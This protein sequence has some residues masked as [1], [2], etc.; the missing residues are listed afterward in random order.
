MLGYICLL[1]NPLACGG[2]E[3][4]RSCDGA[5]TSLSSGDPFSPDKFR[6]LA[7]IPCMYAIWQM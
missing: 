3:V 7:D 4:W 5:G 2:A 6:D 1:A